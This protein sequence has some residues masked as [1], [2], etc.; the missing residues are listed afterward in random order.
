MELLLFFIIICVLFYLASIILPILLIIFL[1]FLIICF[2]YQIYLK[3][4]LHSKKFLDIKKSI[5]K[6]T[7]ECNELNQHI[8]ELKNTYKNYNSDSYGTATYTDT[9]KFNF[10]RPK[11]KDVSTASHTYLCSSTIC[12]NA[13]QQP[14]KYICKYFNINIDEKTLEEFENIL[15][16]FSSAEEG[17]ILLKKERD[18]I[19]TGISDKIPF[20]IKKF[21]LEKVIQELGFDPISFDQYYFPTYEFKYISPGGNSSMKSTT[22]FDIENLNAFVEYLSENIKFK[23]SAKYQRALMTSSLRNKIKARDNYTCQCCKL[24]ISD[25]PNLLLEIDHI[26]PIAKGGLTTEDNLQT[27]CWRCNRSK[28]T[29]IIADSNDVK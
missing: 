11:L 5:E 12:R 18:K 28:G 26:Q 27:L 23:K 6:N 1:A 7:N 29:K 24:S 22:T 20:L 13:Q 8:N 4:F 2:T 9:S 17:K 14:F 3:I 10:K 25:E 19:I 16:N 15:N 21:S